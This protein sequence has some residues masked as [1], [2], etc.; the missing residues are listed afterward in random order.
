MDSAEFTIETSR[1]VDLIIR[2][3]LAQPVSTYVSTGKSVPID[4]AAAASAA[5]LVDT[6]K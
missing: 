5:K 6:R 2:V 1:S 4:M 3:S